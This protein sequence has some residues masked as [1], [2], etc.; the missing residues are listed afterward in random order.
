MVLVFFSLYEILLIMINCD[1]RKNISV[2]ASGNSCNSVE[3]NA[4][5]SDGLYIFNLSD[6][7]DLIFS[8]DSRPDGSLFVETIVTREPYYIVDA[9]SISFT[10]EYEDHYYSQRLTATISS[11]DEDLEEILRDAVHGR[12][13]IALNVIGD[14][15]YRLIGWKEGLSLDEELTIS[16]ENNS[17]EIT[18]DGRTTY[19]VFEADKSNFDLANKE[20]DA[21]FEPLFVAGEVVCDG[22]GWAT[23]KYVVKVNSAGQA[24]DRYDKLCQYSGL[25]QAA[26]KLSGV[27]DGNYYILGTYSSTDFF[28]GRSVRIYDATLCEISGSI[29]VSPSAVTL[30][31]NNTTSAITIS[32][33]DNWELVTYPSYVDISR[34]A[35]GVND[36]VV[37]LYSTENCGTQTLTF[38][39]RAT[40]QTASVTV[41]NDRINI[42]S[43]FVYPNGTTNFTLTP[44]TCGNYTA[45]STLGS[46]TVNDDGTFTVSG[47]SASNTEQTG[48]ITL[49][50][51]SCETVQINITILGNDTA[52]H[53]R[54]IAEW[55]ET[56]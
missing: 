48:T 36:Q 55:C 7:Q 38:R 12:Y 54:A 32:S 35:G 18:F 46:V 52:R 39:N 24:L 5:V 56:D 16:T 2:G 14:E 23:A 27:S 31:S 11:V 29:S 19:P 9:N 8:G 34:T 37:Y 6:I 51:G 20:F 21:I 3:I 25:A 13:V 43:S 26:Y 47:I 53:A 1:L 17:Y 28:N 42:G 15:H 49:T 30:C 44:D 22:Y 4:G 41:H 50:I 33:T 40:R 45:S 10:E